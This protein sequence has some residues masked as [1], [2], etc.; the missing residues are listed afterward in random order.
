MSFYQETRPEIA[1]PSLSDEDVEGGKKKRKMD[2]LI[3]ECICQKGYKFDEMR[4]CEWWQ[5]FKTNKKIKNH[6]RSNFPYKR[7]LSNESLLEKNKRWIS[8]WT[9]LV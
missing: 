7:P 1:R 3:R 2:D 5:N 4:K 8:L 6:I 9:C